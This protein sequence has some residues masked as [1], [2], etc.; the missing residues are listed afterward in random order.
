MK[1]ELDD[2]MR[3][4][5]EVMSRYMEMCINIGHLYGYRN[6]L[7]EFRDFYSTFWNI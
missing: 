2:N 3:T 4:V 6:P 5:H 7:I 1:T